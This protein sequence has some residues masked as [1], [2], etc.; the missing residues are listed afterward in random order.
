VQICVAL[1][2]AT[3]RGGQ[4]SKFELRGR[5]FA[6]YLF[7]HHGDGKVALCVKVPP[8]EQS[9]M[10]AGDP[11][12][13]FSPAY[14]GSKGW[15]ALRIDTPRIDWREVEALLTESYRLVAPKALANAV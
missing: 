3:H 13:Y 11:E 2:E 12:R 7:D 8:G 10:I 5:T 9:R 15:V 14:L 4:H 1:P 6:Y